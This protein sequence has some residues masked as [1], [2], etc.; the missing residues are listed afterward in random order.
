MSLWS[1]L[2]FIMIKVFCSL[3]WFAIRYSGLALIHLAIFCCVSVH[4][5]S[6]GCGVSFLSSQAFLFSLLLLW[7]GNCFPIFHSKK[8]MLFLTQSNINHGRAGWRHQPWFSSETQLGCFF[9]NK[10]AYAVCADL[11]LVCNSLIPQAWQSC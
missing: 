11:C 6:E 3:L 8:Q 10:L 2:C 5:S 1:S 4:P 9:S 7:S